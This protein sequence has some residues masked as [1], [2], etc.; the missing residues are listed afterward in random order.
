MA[1]EIKPAIGLTYQDYVLI[2]EDG[3][4]HEIIEGVH[5]VNPAPSTYHQTVSRRLQFILYQKIELEKRGV[6]FNA[7]V[8]LQLGATN[9]LQPDIVVILE[10]RTQMITPTKIKGV[11]DMVVEILSPSSV[12][13]DTQLKRAVYEKAGVKEYWIVDPFEHEV[14]WLVLR[15]AV[16]Q[17]QPHTGTINL[18]FIDDVAV[19][20][21]EVW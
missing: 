16:Y 11:P 14:D 7:P 15:D 10:D 13:N 6:V 20:L 2:P 3:Q 12:N 19:D 18:T 5:H 21:S 4:R 8:D 1:S 9:I 17:S